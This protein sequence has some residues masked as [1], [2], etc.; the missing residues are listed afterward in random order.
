MATRM[1]ADDKQKEVISLFPYKRGG[2][3]FYS[4]NDR[5]LSIKGVHNYQRYS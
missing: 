1:I 4:P 3:W 5:T 2:F